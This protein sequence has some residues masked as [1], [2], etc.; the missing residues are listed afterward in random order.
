MKICIHPSTR[1]PESGQGSKDWGWIGVSLCGLNLD[2]PLSK[3][4]SPGSG[5]GACC[6]YSGSTSDEAPVS[7]RGYG[8]LNSQEEVRC[9]L[10][11]PALMEQGEEQASM[12]WSHEG[13][14]QEGGVREGGAR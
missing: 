14:G 10:S 7:G 11:E 5:H 13:G 12:G 3:D 8:F 2:P 6:P 1:P 4:H 9:R